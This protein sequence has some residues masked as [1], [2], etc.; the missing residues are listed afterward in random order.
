MKSCNRI[1]NNIV[2]ILEVGRPNPNIRNIQGKALINGWKVS[3][4]F[5]EQPNGYLDPRWVFFPDNLDWDRIVKIPLKGSRDT[6]K[7]WALKEISKALQ[8]KVL[9]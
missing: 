5:Q 2:Q 9:V 3:F 8:S 4:S 1:D 7:Y 6:H